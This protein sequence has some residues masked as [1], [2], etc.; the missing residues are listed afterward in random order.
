MSPAQID[1]ALSVIRLISNSIQERMK[2][3]NELLELFEK[4]RAEDRDFTIE[5]VEF[6]SAKAEL[7]L[8][9]L[10]DLVPTL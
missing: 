6:F 5:E 8:K 10:E 3:H 9:E 1:L 4:A 7:A 2:Q